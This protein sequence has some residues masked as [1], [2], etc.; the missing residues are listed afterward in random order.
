MS[1]KKQDL[2]LHINKRLK[3]LYQANKPLLKSI[4]TRI[5]H[6]YIINIY[7]Y[8][9]SKMK[10]VSYIMNLQQQKEFIR[11]YKQYQ[12]TDKNTIKANLKTYMD[13]SELMIMQIAE[14]TEIPLS[15]IY[16]LRKHSSPYKPEFMTVLIICD[17]LRISITEVLQPISDLI[18]P[19]PKTK[20]DMTTKQKFLQDYNNMNIEDICC[21]YNITVRT[22]QEYNKNFSRDIE[23]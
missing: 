13:K 12:D 6:I 1:L 11:I 7:T 20:W 16:Q 10:G 23:K 3:T 21:K 5:R 9:I 17:L 2:K 4:L 14:Q 22:A 18:V 15:T 8:K 19:E